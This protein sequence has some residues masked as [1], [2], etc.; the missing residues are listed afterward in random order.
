V[1]QT[2]FKCNFHH[3]DHGI[4]IGLPPH[5]N[6]NQIDKSSGNIHFSKIIRSNKRKFRGIQKNMCFAFDFSI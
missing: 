5:K 2:A 1:K 6:G 4:T 3:P